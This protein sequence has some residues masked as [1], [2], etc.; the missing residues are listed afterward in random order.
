[1]LLNEEEENDEINCQEKKNDG[2]LRWSIG[3]KKQKNT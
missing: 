2:R 1:M 3:K